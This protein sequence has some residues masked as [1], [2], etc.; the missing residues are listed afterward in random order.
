MLRDP[1]PV[2][3]SLEA[4]DLV[5][6]ALGWTVAGPDQDA[7]GRVDC[8][9]AIDDAAE[10]IT[11]EQRRGCALHLNERQEHFEAVIHAQPLSG[12]SF[13]LGKGSDDT[14]KSW[15]ESVLAIAYL[16]SMAKLR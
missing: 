16:R 2:Y 10:K 8:P 9:P 15:H 3:E 4:V 11:R 7:K 1:R 12:E 13:A 5:I 14:P 6:G